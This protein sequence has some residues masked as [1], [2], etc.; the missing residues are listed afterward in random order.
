MKLKKKFQNADVIRSSHAVENEHRNEKRE[1]IQKELITS[2]VFGFVLIFLCVLLLR[3]W[4]TS[5]VKP[6][7]TDIVELN[8]SYL[9]AHLPKIYVLIPHSSIQ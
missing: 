5:D 6:L 2:Y 7:L 1:S 4:T 9:P 3:Q 8:V